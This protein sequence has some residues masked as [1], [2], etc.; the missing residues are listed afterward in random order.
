MLE[1][2]N[3]EKYI[4]NMND[5]S[6]ENISIDEYNYIKLFLG[7]VELLKEFSLFIREKT[8]DLKKF[9]YTE[10]QIQE[11][12]ERKKRKNLNELFMN[13]KNIE[14]L[15]VSRATI[16]NEICSLLREIDTLNYSKRHI[17]EDKKSLKVVDAQIEQL[18]KRIEKFRHLLE[19]SRKNDL[20]AQRISSYPKV[21]G[22]DELEGR[23]KFNEKK[24]DFIIEKMESD[25]MLQ[26]SRE[27]DLQAKRIAN[28]EKKI[29]QLSNHINAENKK[30]HNSLS[31]KLNTVPFEAHHAICKHFLLTGLEQDPVA[32]CNDQVEKKEYSLE[33]FGIPLNDYIT[34][35]DEVKKQYYYE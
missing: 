11:L 4:C 27:K 20:S 21:K 14:S 1:R 19:Q 26:V 32:L 2:S 8:E 31:K 15:S 13:N 25:Y 33:I 7:D 3:S 29:A 6:D 28:E 35:L 23:Y 5:I 17:K 16:Q 22:K 24:K 10:K 9:H 18:T 30:F 34:T 12:V